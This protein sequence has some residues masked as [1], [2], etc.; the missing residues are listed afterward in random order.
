MHGS[1]VQVTVKFDILT[2][3]LENSWILSSFQRQDDTCL[4]A[5]PLCQDWFR[6]VWGKVGQL[7][8][9]GMQAVDQPNGLMAKNLASDHG[10]GEST[11]A[12]TSGACIL[13]REGTYG[14]GSGGHALV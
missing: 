9:L 12:A 4:S 2:A 1:S 7:N 3:V 5:N 8:Y 11:G 14:T 6:E 10:V 13:C